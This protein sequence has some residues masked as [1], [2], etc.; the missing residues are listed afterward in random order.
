MLARTC[1]IFSKSMSGHFKNELKLNAT[2]SV[3]CTQDTTLYP[4]AIH[5]SMPPA[6]GRTRL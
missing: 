6:N 2:Y 1:L 3:H 4:A 5:A